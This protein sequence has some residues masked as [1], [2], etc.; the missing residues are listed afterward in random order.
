MN[1][2]FKRNITFF[3]VPLI[4]LFIAGAC[5]KD[6]SI[7]LDNS[8]TDDVGVALLDTISASTSTVQ[9]DN[10]PSSVSGRLLVGKAT[11]DQSGSVKS[12][13]YFR[14]GLTSLTQDI[15]EA[16]ALD[17]INIHIPTAKSPIAY[18]YGDTTKNQTIR[19][20]RLTEDLE[21]K[22]LSGGIQ[23]NALPFYVTG[24]SLFSNQKF[25][26]E[27]TDIGNV[28]FKPYM[29]LIDTLKIRLNQ[30]VG[31]E[32]FDL[33]KTGATAVSS[34]ENFYNYFKGLALVP[35][36]NNT[37]VLRFTDTVDVNINY[38]YTGTDG[39]KKTGTKTLSIVDKSYESNHIEYDRSETAF[40]DLTP[41][42]G[43]PTSATAG[44]TYIQAG[45]GV[46][47][48]ISFPSLKGFLQ[49]E[50]ISINKAELVIE[51]LPRSS[52][53]LYPNS[54]GASLFVADHAGV[55]VSFVGTPYQN[56]IQEARY[57]PGTE[58]GS[59]GQFVF[60]LVQ[61][62]KNVKLNDAY[63][64]T[65]LYLTNNRTELF[66]SFSTTFLATENGKPKIKLNILYTKF[67]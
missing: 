66:N 13:A 64:D 62:L 58:T 63:D 9:M 44:V 51:T 30:S 54:T 33:L 19:V 42:K 8:T 60:D 14:L 47:A 50:G 43:I 12:T 40:S 17:S 1:Q 55:P 18:T 48:K 37:A 59:N 56:A 21:L 15:P 16:A 39:A 4:I 34:N 20:H 65:S 6:M 27:P 28:T 52:N 49:D 36:D 2:L 53:E 29:G 38:S 24:P 31:Q 26:Y 10:L 35:D 46:V 25:T 32:L 11:Q 45:T 22:T 3:A 5:D 23:N 67:K 7:V 61:H 41:Q 57:I